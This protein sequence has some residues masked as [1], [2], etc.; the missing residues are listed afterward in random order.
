MVFPKT[1]GQRTIALIP[2]ETLNA[3]HNHESSIMHIYRAANFQLHLSAFSELCTATSGPVLTQPMLT[4]L[5][6]LIDVSL[7]FT[8]VQHA[9]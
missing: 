2:V 4:F 9:S 6:S 7:Y 1:L 3:S 8:V 5:N